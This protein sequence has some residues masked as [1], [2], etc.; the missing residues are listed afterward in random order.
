[1]EIATEAAPMS[2]VRL[3]W[4]FLFIS[5][6]LVFATDREL[7]VYSLEE[8]A[9]IAYEFH[10]NAV[11]LVQQAA[12]T[13]DYGECLSYF[14]AAVRL[15]PDNPTYLT[16]LGVTE[17]RVGELQKAKHRFQKALFI[18]PERKHTRDNLEILKE[19]MDAED[20]ELTTYGTRYAQDQHTILSVPE[21]LP[22]EIK[23]LKA[24]DAYGQDLL[25]GKV[26]LKKKNRSCH[27]FIFIYS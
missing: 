16:D 2:F 7:P 6:I 23:L 19:Y 18:N 14:R 26:S 25:S 10:E 11:M 4:L 21:V 3:Q 5:L 27:V 1:M 24:D 13:N 17:M 20:F 9:K 15:Q 12:D 22:I 8:R